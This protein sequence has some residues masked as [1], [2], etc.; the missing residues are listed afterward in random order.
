[1]KC[2]TRRTFGKKK[3]INCRVHLD[4]HLTGGFDCLFILT[5]FRKSQLEKTWQFPCL[6]ILTCITAD[7]DDIHQMSVQIWGAV[8]QAPLPMLK[9]VK[10]KMATCPV[11]CHK[12]H[13]SLG[14][15]SDKFLDLLLDISLLWSLDIQAPTK[16]TC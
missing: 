15:P 13:E 4:I 5:E 12:F 16:F 2:T 1:M 9:L 14:P 6:L 11:L 8:A 3:K 10:K 7:F